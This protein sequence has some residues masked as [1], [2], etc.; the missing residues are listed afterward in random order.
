MSLA[1]FS[2]SVCSTWNFSFWSELVAEFSHDKP[3]TRWNG[4]FIDASEA[5][6]TGAAGNKVWTDDWGCTQPLPISND[7]GH[8]DEACFIDEVL[9]PR[10]TQGRV[11]SLSALTIAGIEDL[12]YSVDYNAADP[13]NED[14]LDPA[15]C[16]G[17]SDL[18]PEIALQKGKVASS[19][20]AKDK[21]IE[22]GKKLLSTR[23]RMQLLSDEVHQADDSPIYVGD[24]VVMVFYR[25]DGHLFEVRVTQ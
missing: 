2:A 22:Y 10:L 24:R 4:D 21:A 8:W 11:A 15:C 7:E 14:S 5:R 23:S 9:S 16:T 17:A 12:G 3:G 19:N 25:H 18:Q 1:T 6:Y 20:K 13:Y